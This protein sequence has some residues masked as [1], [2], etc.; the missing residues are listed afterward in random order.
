M[1]KK[2]FFIT[3]CIVAEIIL[4]VKIGE[5][6]GAMNTFLLVLAGMILGILIIRRSLK[7]AISSFNEKKVNINVLFL[8][9]AGF[10]FLMPGFI[11]DILAILLLTPAVKNFIL[12]FYAKRSG[13]NDS[14]VFRAK[15]PDGETDIFVHKNTIEGKA[16]VINPDNGIRPEKDKAGKIEDAT[17]IDEDKKQ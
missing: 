13:T 16:R 8:P 15:G 14:F 11:S 6:I 10:L 17:I 9:L 4:L 12:K 3:A 5:L 2:S 1:H 7:S